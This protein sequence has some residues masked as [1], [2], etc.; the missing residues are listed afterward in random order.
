M[1][2][3][4]CPGKRFTAKTRRREEKKIYPG[5]TEGTEKKKENRGEGD[6]CGLRY[7]L[8]LPL[9]CVVVPSWLNRSMLVQARKFA[10]V[11]KISTVSNTKDAAQP[12]ARNQIISNKSVAGNEDWLHARSAPEPACDRV[13]LPPAT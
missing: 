1:A 6:L 5:A 3:T 9:R 13:S 11:A 7:L 4:K 10:Y 8:F 12:R 2:A